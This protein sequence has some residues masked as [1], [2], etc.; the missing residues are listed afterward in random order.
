MSSVEWCIL[1]WGDFDTEC[2]FFIF[3]W[4]CRILNVSYAEQRTT[5][6]TVY[7]TLSPY[8]VLYQVAIPVL[9]SVLSYGYLINGQLLYC[10]HFFWALPIPVIFPTASPVPHPAIHTIL[11]ATVLRPANFCTVIVIFHI[12]S[13]IPNL[14]LHTVIYPGAVLVQCLAD[15]CTLYCILYS[16]FSGDSC[17]M[18]NRFLYCPLFYF[19]WQWRL[20]K[21]F[22]QRA[23]YHTVYSC[24]T[25]SSGDSCPMSSVDCCI[26]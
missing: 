15:F 23:Q 1:Y 17:P 2:I 13:E 4:L 11:S 14:V 20:L 12:A 9:S 25:Q 18:V 19:F 3:F 21:Y 10:M 6:W 24:C 16:L 26:L 7:C 22:I 5:S 8:T